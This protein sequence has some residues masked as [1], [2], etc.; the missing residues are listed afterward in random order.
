MVEDGLG[1]DSEEHK[2]GVTD[3]RVGSEA[4]RLKLITLRSGRKELCLRDRGSDK[5][6]VFRRK[7]VARLRCLVM[8]E[9]NERCQD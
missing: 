2:D 3:K 8:S 5:G 9:K 6:W 7:K 4:S 1:C